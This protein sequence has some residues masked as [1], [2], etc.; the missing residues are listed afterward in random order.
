MIEMKLGSIMDMNHIVSCLLSTIH[1]VGLSQFVMNIGDIEDFSIS[2]FISEDTNKSIGS[3][4][5]A[6]FAEHK[7]TVLTNIPT[8]TSITVRP[9]LHNILQVLVDQARDDGACPEPDSLGDIVD[10][11]DLLL[12]QERALEML[13]QGDSPY[14]DLFRMLYSF[15]EDMMSEVGKNGLSKMNALVSSLTEMQSNQGGEL[16]YPGDLFYQDVDVALNGLNAAI[17][18]GVS[19]LSV[20][21]LNS[22]G[23]PIKVLQPVEGESSMLN[24]TALIGVGQ[25]PFRAEFRLL[26]KGKGDEVE[27]H[28]DLVLSLDLKS[29]GMMLEVLAHIK[30]TPFMN[31]PL[32]DVLNL[33]CWL[34]TVVTP[35]LDT[36]GLRVG[37]IDSGIMLKNLALAV[38]EAQLGIECISCSS[39]LIL[40]MA[41]K[42]G[43]PE[44]IKDTTD[45][46]N[47]IFDYASNLLGGEFV[48]SGLD[49]LLNEAAMK[50]P[51]SSSYN[52]NFA[53]LKY[54]ELI[55]PQKD[56]D[57]YGFLIAI[58]AVIAVSMVLAAL[59]FVITRCVTRRCHNRWVKTLN[60]TQLL[61]LEKMQKDEGEKEKDLNS[62]M[63]SLVKSEDVPLFL[64]LFMPIVIVG[65][66]ALFL[67]GH[68]SLGGTVNICGSFAGEEF[69][70]GGF[71][72]FSMLKSTI[73]MWNAGA[74]A[75]AILIVIF[76]GVWP[77]TKQLFTLYIW[78]APTR[79]LS[80]KRRG[81][82]LHWLDV[83]GKWSM[84]SMNLFYANH[85]LALCYICS[86]SLLH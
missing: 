81:S 50:C 77:Y 23:A 37:E 74:K 80:S 45:V 65:N 29:V 57:S 1:S 54:D 22:L 52:Q 76:S 17:E 71:F 2:G 21:G 10:F 5:D 64:R 15:L 12:S 49:K 55:A 42:L 43:L 85:I 83:L 30:E 24:N 86:C 34:A 63:K 6:I 18:L 82:I 79:W 72:E 39:P 44:S 53:G 75:L 9:I 38:E 47:M 3:M 26:I 60:R 62:R 73:E 33:Q 27:V 78:F 14:G 4:T 51:H 16:Y 19:D 67:S 7:S 58:I 8:F 59:I 20:S 68:L 41:S 61:E 25:D 56:E 28:N 35:V 32:Q 69:F 48:Q 11:R 13:G 46:A 70:V 36:Y 31:F 66:I 40:E 84:V